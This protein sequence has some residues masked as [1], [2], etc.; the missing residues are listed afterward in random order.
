[1][2]PLRLAHLSRWKKGVACSLKAYKYTKC[3]MC[4][5]VLREVRVHSQCC[6]LHEIIQV[7]S[8][9]QKE[10]HAHRIVEAH[11]APSND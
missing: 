3:L 2:S 6:S 8:L 1:M 7:V 5:M 10:H 9:S 4:V 11:R